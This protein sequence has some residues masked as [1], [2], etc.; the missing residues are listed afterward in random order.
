MCP[1]SNYT[2]SD[3]GKLL[4]DQES[5]FVERKENWAGDSPEKG[6]EAVCAFAN[7]LPGHGRPGVL[8]VGM[9]DDGTPSSIVITIV[10]TDELLRTL[11]DIKTDGQILPPPSITV[12]KRRLRGA[13]MAVVIVQPSDAPPVRYKGRIWIRIGPR[14]AVATIQEERILN[15]RRRHRDLPFDVQGIP[16]ATISDLNRLLFEQEYLPNAFAPDILQANERTYEERLLSCKMITP[17]NNPTLIG[18]LVIGKNS[19]D[20]LPGA[21]IQFLRIQGTELSDSVV[22]EELLDGPLSQVLRRLDEKVDSHNRVAVDIKSASKEWRQSPYPKV[23]LQ[24]LIRNAVMHRT[25]EGTN[26]PIRV[27]WFEDRI[28]IYSPG[29]PY[30]TVTIENFGQPGFTDYRNP[31]LA[32][33][34]KVLGFVQRFGIGIQTAQAEMKKNGNPPVEFSVEPNIVLCILRRNS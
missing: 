1:I 23:A 9:K 10:I 22:D 33:A 8:F 13:E 21:Y 32:E 31:H 19:R 11:A 20:W 27:F 18:L 2:D 26:S 25:Y 24:Q 15:E 6:R 30:G 34:M 12:R 3:L 5:D 14:R 7:D 4:A 29:G 28:E 17:S 16:S